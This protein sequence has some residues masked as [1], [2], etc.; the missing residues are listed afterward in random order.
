[1]LGVKLQMLKNMVVIHHSSSESEG[2]TPDLDGW[3]SADE[4]VPNQNDFDIDEANMADALED[5]LRLPVEDSLVDATLV[6]GGDGGALVD[7]MPLAGP[8]PLADT[9]PDTQ[10]GDPYRGMAVPGVAFRANRYSPEVQEQMR[11]ECEAWFKIP[12]EERDAAWQ[13]ELKEWEEA[14]RRDRA[15]ETGIEAPREQ[16]SDNESGGGTDVFG[17]LAESDLEMP[18]MAADSDGE[19]ALVEAAVAEDTLVEGTQ[20]ED[21]LV[22]DTL[23]EFV[24]AEAGTVDPYATPEG[25]KPRIGMDAAMELSAVS[26]HSPI[27]DSDWEAAMGCDSS[28]DEQRQQLVVVDTQASCVGS[29]FRRDRPAVVDAVASALRSFPIAAVSTGDQ[30]ALARVERGGRG[31]GRG[32][33]R[34]AKDDNLQAKAV[35]GLARGRGRSRGR[36]GGRGRSWVYMFEL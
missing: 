29:G 35:S 1:M 18:D 32:R 4:T 28:G 26:G 33:G 34:G 7:A 31:R 13:A 17:S 16:A 25:K 6:D 12:V 23:V 15:V 21:T 20:A 11:A 5:A 9:Q 2:S 22:E 30:N 24:P 27:G 36:G 19:T 8:L 14:R 3:S 10:P